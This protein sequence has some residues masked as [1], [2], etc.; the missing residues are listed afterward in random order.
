MVSALDPRSTRTHFRRRSSPSRHT[1]HDARSRFARPTR[2]RSTQSSLPKAPLVDPQ[3]TDPRFERG[4]RDSEVSSRSRGAIDTPAGRAQGAFDHRP[5]LRGKGARQLERSVDCTSGGQP[6]L[7]DRELVRLAHD[8]RP[9]DDVLQLPDVTGPRVRP[10]P[11]QSLFVDSPDRLAHLA[12][13]PIDEVPSEDGDV[14]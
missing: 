11:L 12:R 4:T 1:T 14:L 7:V 13:I 2:L 8:H 6:A 9:L 3:R 10:K 5:L